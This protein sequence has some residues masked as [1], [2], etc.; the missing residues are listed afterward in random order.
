MT[1][2]ARSLWPGRPRPPYLRLAI[3]LIAAPA[4]L[5]AIGTGISFLIAGASEE[6]L[7]GTMAVTN[8]AGIALGV[9]GGLLLVIAGLPGVA[10]LWALGQRS[11]LAWSA[12]GVVLGAGASAILGIAQQGQVSQT[13][14][15]VGTVFCWLM[16]L[17]IRAIAGVRTG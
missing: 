6:T 17:L 13:S 4:I 8:Q 2:A 7:E 16:F 14:L 5:A 3:A 10:T 1:D 12:T 9:L 15:T 11:V